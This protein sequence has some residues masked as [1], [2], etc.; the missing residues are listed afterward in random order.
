M[1]VASLKNASKFSHK[2]VSFVIT[3]ENVQD[4]SKNELITFLRKHS[5]YTLFLLGN[6]QEHGP[7]LAKA[8]NSANFKII[9]KDTYIFAAFCLCRR[10][11][12]LLFTQDLEATL[13]LIL[14]ECRREIL[15]NQLELNGV[16]GEWFQVKPLWNYLKEENWIQKDT[17]VSK[18]ILYT[19]N[20][21][22]ASYTPQTNVRLL[23][24]HDYAKWRPLNE[25]YLKE[26]A[27]PSVLSEEEEFQEYARRVEKRISWGMFEKEQLKSIANL[28]A[29]AFD[30]AQLGGVFTP[31]EFRKRGYSKSVVKQVLH[32]CKYLHQIKKLIIFTGEENL[33]ARRVYE[34]LGGTFRGHFAL[35]FGTPKAESN[36]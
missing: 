33:P 11:T 4:N 21:K 5:D 22:D 31:S 8:P 17:Y 19:I 6:L 27:L 3:I 2:E 34:S 35:L 28:N 14:E 12:L 32:D 13:P 9:R 26:M 15:E 1:A 29:Y 16:I 30:L 36:F 20:L 10:G 23:S 18:E 25:A 7:F 24:L